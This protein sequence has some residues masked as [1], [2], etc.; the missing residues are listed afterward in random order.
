M[1]DQ[2]EA[3]G[4]G[5]LRSSSQVI[6]EFAL[7]MQKRVSHGLMWSQ[8]YTG[9]LQNP[10]GKG[11][12]I[13]C[14]NTL[15]GDWPWR[16]ALKHK[17]LTMQSQMTLRWKKLLARDECKAVTQAFQNNVRK[18]GAQSESRHHRKRP[19]RGD[20]GWWEQRRDSHGNCSKYDLG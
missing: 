8:V 20:S 10:E 15:G 7:F 5:I 2:P 16:L 4:K 1:V 12:L 17:T 18:A 19:F 14:P 6:S 3:M 11:R 13:P 9:R